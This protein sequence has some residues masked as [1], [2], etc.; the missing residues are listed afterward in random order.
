M[1]QIEAPMLM[2]VAEERNRMPANSEVISIIRNTANVM[3]ISSAAYFARSLIRSLYATRKIPPMPRGPQII[4]AS[5]GNSPLPRRG[6]NTQ[7]PQVAA[8]LH[9]SLGLG[10][11]GVDARASIGLDRRQRSGQGRRQGRIDIDAVRALREAQ[12]LQGT[13]LPL[14]HAEVRVGRVVVQTP[15]LVDTV[16]EN[17]II[18]VTGEDYAVDAPARREVQKAESRGDGQE[19][20]IDDRVEAPFET[21]LRAFEHM[22]VSAICERQFV[23]SR[24][25]ARRLARFRRRSWQCKSEPLALDIRTDAN[26]GQGA[27]QAFAEP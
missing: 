5:N 4:E 26:R 6:D 16:G 7:N 10:A 24:R 27:D 23:E 9:N 19:R 8:T 17:G 1:T 12:R 3:P 20:G 21:L 18:R 13:Q 11:H 14:Q 15:P 22:C 2:T 25:I